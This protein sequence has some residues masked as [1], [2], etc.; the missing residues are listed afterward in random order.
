MEETRTETSDA[1][2][3]ASGGTIGVSASASASF[4]SASSSGVVEFHSSAG[5]EESATTD[6]RA[7][8]QT[9]VRVSGW[10]DVPYAA[11]SMHRK[12]LRAGDTVQRSTS[13]Q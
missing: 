12:Y 9:Y 11:R 6:S 1:S 4:G 5:Q 2:A 10:A 7:M 3:G 13:M 8:Y